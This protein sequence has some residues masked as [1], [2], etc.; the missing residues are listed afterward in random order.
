[1]TVN[2]ALEFDEAFYVPS[3]YNIDDSK[4]ETAHFIIATHTNAEGSAINGE[5]YNDIGNKTTTI[6]TSGN[7]ASEN[8]SKLKHVTVPNDIPATSSTRITFW[9][10]TTQSSSKIG[11]NSV[12]YLYLDNIK[13]YIKN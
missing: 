3:G 1:M 10:G 12:Y 6:Y 7:F 9:P 2:V 13:V 5:N 4:N 8:I 11:A